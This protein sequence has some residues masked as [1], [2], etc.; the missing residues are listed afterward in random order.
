M[1]GKL[2]LYKECGIFT[3]YVMI[4]I[5]KRSTL[6]ESVIVLRGRGDIQEGLELG[7]DSF[8]PLSVAVSIANASINEPKNTTVCRAIEPHRWLFQVGSVRERRDDCK[9]KRK[10]SDGTVTH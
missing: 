2:T 5:I 7:V 3:W 6:Y 8:N 1:Y 10:V 9:R 4:V